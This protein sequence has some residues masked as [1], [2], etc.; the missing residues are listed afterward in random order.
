MRLFQ[1]Q[2]GLPSKVGGHRPGI[3]HVQWYN[4]ACR[5]LAAVG[6]YLVDGDIPGGEDSG[7]GCICVLVVA[8]MPQSLR[9]VFS[10]HEN[11][12]SLVYY[13]SVVTDS[14]TST[15]ITD[16]ESDEHLERFYEA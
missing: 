1:T 6:P 9:I 13:I 7:E 5:R 16:S 3:V 8:S 11:V 12:H 10:S 4:R 15:S 2:G 14:S